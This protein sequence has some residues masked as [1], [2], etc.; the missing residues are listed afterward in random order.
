MVFAH[1]VIEHIPKKILSITMSEIFR[2]LKKNGYLVI[3]RT[4]N[5]YALTELLIKSHNV[6]FTQK[7]IID[8]CL[9]NSFEVVSHKMTDFFPE[10][11]PGS[12]QS[13]LNVFTPV[14]KFFDIVINYMP[15][16]G[17]SHHHFLILK[18][19]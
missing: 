14:L 7:E 16:R 2:I 9:E 1:A 13:V 15:L 5:K 8:L 12:L 10:V 19:L 3:A 11:A 6:R 17:L 18:K 4:P